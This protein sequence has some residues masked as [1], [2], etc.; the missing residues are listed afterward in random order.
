MERRSYAFKHLRRAS[1]IVSV[2]LAKPLLVVAFVSS[3]MWRAAAAQN[4]LPPGQAQALQQAI[5]Q[6]PA[7][8]DQL[9]NR[10]MSS[11]M[12]PDQIRARLA[13]SGYPS[14]LLD[15]YL[16]PPSQA[17]QGAQPGAPELA[18]FEALGLSVSF[19]S[20][21]IRPDTGA[22]P[23][24]GEA[25]SPESLRVGNYVFGVDVFHRGTT[26]FLPVLAGPVPPDYHVGPGDQLVLILT[27]D[28]ESAYALS[29]TREGFMLIPGA[30]Q[31]FVSNL[32]LDQLRGVLYTR[33]GKVYSS[34]R[35]GADAK[36][37]LDVS[38]TRVRVNQV[39]VVGEVK[40]PG[41]YQLSAL[42]TA[43]SAIYV[44]GGVTARSNMRHIQVRRQE[45]VVATVDLYDYLLRGEKGDDIRLETGDV[46]FVPLHGTRAQITGAVLRPAVYELKPGE[47]L[48]DLLRAAGGFGSDAALDRLAIY[49]IVP[50]A[51][52]GSGP[53]PRSV[54]DVQ[55]PVRQGDLADP[56]GHAADQS[57]GAVVIPTVGLENGD[58][59]VVDAI[60]SLDN[61]Y[62]VTITGP[63]NKPGRYPWR[64]GMT[65]RQLLIQA[66]GPRAWA[67]LNEA[68][69][70]RLPADRSQGQ[71]AQTIHVPLDSTYLTGRDSAGRYIGPPGP[72]FSAMGAAEVTLEP[73]DDV[74]I[75]IQSGFSLQRSVT[76]GGEVRFP[77]TYV[78]ASGKD[79]LGDVMD[80]A[81]G[82]TAR[83][84][85]EGIRFIRQDNVGRIN[86]DLPRALKERDSRYNIALRDGDSIVVPEYQAS[87]RVMG[88]VN[89]PI[90]VLWEK[91][92]DLAYYLSAAGG[93]NYKAEISRISVQYANG[94]VRTRS[95]TLVVFHGDPVPGPGSVVVVPERDMSARKPDIVT[96]LGVLAQLVAATVTLV[97]VTKK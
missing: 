60:P 92:R 90:S 47:G 39:Y 8:A 36:T 32:T 2:R 16:G 24:A 76:L 74:L 67:D 50:L 19:P 22:V 10:L 87:V 54:V 17:G 80:R 11:G 64:A 51:A 13:A 83:A 95:T 86:V 44:A 81:G 3:L 42:G 93:T 46:V 23:T 38:V 31:M 78:L 65:L 96:V 28:I 97:V 34:V 94:D 49:R 62:Y 26:Q 35:P 4:Q 85:P 79:R 25:V 9:R 55:L 37:H 21:L 56:P 15:A 1:G 77:G 48:P 68:E 40:Q 73:Y 66:R 12:T 59:V 57:A 41:A 91:G 88:A 29:V 18:A 75:R 20:E 89:A 43:L 30:G 69:I 5:L 14:N 53:F 61:S 7:L 63:V 58:S 45:K 70:A 84:Y 72:A 52:R 33:L 27:G 82:L 6:N 71:L